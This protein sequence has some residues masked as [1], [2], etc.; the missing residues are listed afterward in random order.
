MS[1]I[2]S[3]NMFLRHDQFAPYISSRLNPLRDREC[4]YSVYVNTFGLKQVESC[5][6]KITFHFTDST[7]SKFKRLV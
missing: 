2:Y 4:I 5:F 3:S 6:I 7:T 1:V